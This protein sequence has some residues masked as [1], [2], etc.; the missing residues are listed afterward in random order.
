MN[1][2][3]EAAGR[4]NSWGKDHEAGVTLEHSR[5]NKSRVAGADE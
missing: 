2:Q 5:N 4:G 1:S 3:K